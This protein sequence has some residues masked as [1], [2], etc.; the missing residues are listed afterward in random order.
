MNNFTQY[1]HIIWDWNGT[2]LNDGWLFVEVMNIILKRRKMRPITLKKYREIFGFPVK[3]YYMKLGF[4]FGSESFESSGLEFIKEYEKSCFKAELYPQVIPL[5]NEL[6]KLGISHSILSAQHQMF[7]DDLT[8]YY[9]IRNQFICI[10]GL[11]NHY[12]HSKV[13]NGIDWINKIEIDPKE[14]LMIGDTDHDFDVAVAMGVDCVLLCHG[15]NSISR[16]QNTGAMV[17]NDLMELSKFFKV[18]LNEIKQH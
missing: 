7:L 18:D 16:L 3:D 11:D 1:K 2:L 10:S 8:Q 13:E 9:K 4:D 17:I 15:H 14:I 6:N 5:L 12:A